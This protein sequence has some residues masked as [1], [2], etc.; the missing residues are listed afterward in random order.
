MVL[1]WLADIARDAGLDVT[2]IGGWETRGRYDFDGTPWGVLCHHT[3]GAGPSAGDIPS[4]HELIHG[5][6]LPNPL[7][8]PLCNYGL[9]RD[10]HVYVVAAGS[11]NHAGEG[12]WPGLPTNHANDRLVGIEAEN[13]GYVQGPHAEPWPI[14]QMDAY[15]RLCAAILEHIDEPVTHCLG[16]KEWAPGRKTDPTFDMHLFRARVAEEMAPALTS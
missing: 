3:A 6:G 14:V 16:H 7:S 11:A 4:L 9:A 1:L 13:T 15:V 5:R 10:G 8:G 12:H 2:E